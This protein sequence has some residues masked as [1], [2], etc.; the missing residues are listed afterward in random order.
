MIAFFSLSSER[1]FPILVPGLVSCR[2]RMI[3]NSA[4]KGLLEHWVVPRSV[5]QKV[6]RHL[7]RS[8]EKIGT[9]Q[10]LSIESVHHFLVQARLQLLQKFLPL[11]CARLLPQ[12][13]SSRIDEVLKFGYSMIILHKILP[14]S[15]ATVSINY[16]L[17]LLTP[18]ES[19]SNFSPE[20]VLFCTEKI[21]YIE[22]HHLVPRQRTV[23]RSAINPRSG[24]CDQ[25]LLNQ[26][27][28]LLEVLIRQCVFCK[29]KQIF[30]I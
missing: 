19:F 16:F 23:D 7:P 30:A 13:R 8:L 22:W 1:L 12:C 9:Q 28:L 10:Q 21:D 14:N 3:F 18:W 25:P 29:E 20:K 11:F 17:A 26:H 27:T 4:P 2:N 6:F 5:Y 15:N 24:P